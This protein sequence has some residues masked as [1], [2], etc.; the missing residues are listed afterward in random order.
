MGWKACIHHDSPPP[1][2]MPGGSIRHLYESIAPFYIPTLAR[3]KRPELTVRQTLG[4]ST[5]S[6]AERLSF[7]TQHRAIQHDFSA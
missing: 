7:Q 2:T 6:M 4:S 1:R 3:Q 5:S